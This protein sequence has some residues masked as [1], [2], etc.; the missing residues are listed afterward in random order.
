[1]K[2]NLQTISSG[3]A[4]GKQIV[5]VEGYGSFHTIYEQFYELG[6]HTLYLSHSKKEHDIKLCYCLLDVAKHLGC[7]VD[8][9][10]ESL[11]KGWD[12]EFDFYPTIFKCVKEKD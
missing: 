12:E 10:V 8:E 7:D 5:V 3:R 4:A 6:M 9:L 1:M 2:V 11:P